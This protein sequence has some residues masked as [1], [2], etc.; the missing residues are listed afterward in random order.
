MYLSSP[1]EGEDVR[2]SPE[3]ASRVSLGKGIAPQKNTHLQEIHET[4][5]LHEIPMVGPGSTFYS[6]GGQILWMKLLQR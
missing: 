5:I 4:M 1:M 2:L 3:T 6:L